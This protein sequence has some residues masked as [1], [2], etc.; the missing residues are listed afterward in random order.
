MEKIKRAIFIAAGEGNRLRPV[1]LE[2]PKP[3]IEVHGK[4]MID[5]SLEALEKQGINEIYLVVGYKKEKFF[6]AYGEN[7]HIHLIENP[8]YLKG[9]NI[10]SLYHAREYLPGS[11]VLE[12]DLV[13]KEDTIL[14]PEIGKSGYLASWMDPAT[15]WLLTMEDG[16]IVNYEVQAARPGYRLWGI[17]MWTQEDGKR[18][19]EEIAC[20]YE[21]GN[22]SIYWDQVA[23]GQ[24]R[25][26][27]DMGIRE[28]G[29]DAILEIDTL[30]EL[31]AID[32]SYRKYREGKE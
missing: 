21:K 20:E 14:N 4:R 31:I 12:A 19:A 7:P 26:K 2:T 5:R 1:T 3:L 30:D 32:E 6:E 11:F 25:T 18:L 10:T 27:Y 29:A 22:W 24:C 16:R 23:L 15:E 13:V 9:N 8:D 28:I 17:S